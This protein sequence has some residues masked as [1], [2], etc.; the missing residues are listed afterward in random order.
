M[1]VICEKHSEAL[2]LALEL[3]GFL[4]PTL[5]AGPDL[6]PLQEATALI[7]DHC[8]NFAGKASVQMLESPCCLC[9]VNNA[10]KSKRVHNPERVQVDD[11]VNLAAD[12][13]EQRHLEEE[14]RTTT[15]LAQ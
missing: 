10:L 1:N 15:V 4:R 12:E 3:R 14:G 6:K 8:M 13:V 11:W 2:H 5:G 7:L 9:F